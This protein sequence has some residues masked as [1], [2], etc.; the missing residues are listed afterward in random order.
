MTQRANPRQ[1]VPRTAARGRSKKGP[2]VALGLGVIILV[3]LASIGPG[4]L[5][6]VL[7]RLVSPKAQGTLSLTILHSNDTWGYLFPCG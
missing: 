7:G 2:W 1:K 6:G 3:F 4:R 5:F